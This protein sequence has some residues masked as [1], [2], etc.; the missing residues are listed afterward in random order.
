MRAR[1]QPFGLARHSGKNAVL[2][3]CTITGTTAAGA[4]VALSIGGNTR[5]ATVTGSTWR[6]DLQASDITAMADG[7]ETIRATASLSGGSTASASRTILVDTVAPSI[8]SLALSS[9]TGAQNSTL[10]A[11]DVASVTL[12][13][14]RIPGSGVCTAA[15]S[16]GVASE[17]LAMYF[18]A[19]GDPVLFS[20]SGVVKRPFHASLIVASLEQP[21]QPAPG[22]PLA[23]QIARQQASQR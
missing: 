9:A 15:Q 19:P 10:N 20:T 16:A 3:A 12:T 22:S 21:V 13:I 6:Y 14:G 5:I 23:T 18:S 2:M 1:L 17:E 4:A 8:S 11:G 7:G